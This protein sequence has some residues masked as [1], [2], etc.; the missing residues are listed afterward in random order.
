M[1]APGNVDQIM[2]RTQAVW[3]ADGLADLTLG[4]YFAAIGLFL[5]AESVTPPAHRSG[6]S[7]EW[8]ARCC[9]ILGGV[10]AGWILKRLKE[11]L[12]FPRAGYVNFE[13]PARGKSGMARLADGRG[14]IR[15]RGG[16]RR[17][18]TG[19]L[20]NLT[21]VFGLIGFATCLYLWQRLGLARYLVMA[22]WSAIAGIALTLTGLSME[23]GGAAFWL[24][25]G[26]AMMAIGVVAWRRFDGEVG[27]EARE[28][29]HA[30]QS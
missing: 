5:Y 3:Y 10:A 2:K 27:R 23:Q 18:G 20:Q 9:I 28:A 6:C 1:N 4:G 26:A 30:E 17:G 15:S 7:G 14:G 16:G 25:F 11:R 19:R 22:V 29:G 8:A 12:V 13:R 21:L 24:L